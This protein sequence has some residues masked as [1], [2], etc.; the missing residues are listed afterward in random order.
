MG[1]MK[2]LHTSDWHLGRALYGRKRYDEFSDFLDWIL[3][4][5]TRTNID[6]LVIAGDIFDTGTPSNRAQ[7]LYYNFLCNIAKSPCRHVIIIGGNHDSPSFLSAPGQL[8]RGLDIHVVGAMTECPE[9]EVILLTDPQGKAEALICAVPYLRD[10]DIRT[11]TPGESLDDKNHKLIQGLQDHYARIC[12]MAVARQTALIAEGQAKIPIIATGHLFTAGGQTIDGDGVRDL[13][14]GSLAHMGSDLFP[15]SIDYLALGH[16]HVPQIVGKKNHF[17]YCGSPIA[18]GF[19]EAK[20]QKKIILVEFDGT[21]PKIQEQDVPIFQKLKL[22]RGDWDHIKAEITDLC[23]QQESVWLEIDYIGNALI[24]NLPD[25]IQDLI[26]DSA[27]EV[28]RIKN[29]SRNAQF[30]ANSEI[31]ETLDDLTPMEVFERCLVAYDVDSA[32]QAPLIEAYQDILRH[33][34]EQDSRAE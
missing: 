4:Y 23:A 18:M 31:R 27:L 5:I 6:I 7:Q 10:K 25:Q 8:L 15:E 30:S 16:L 24:S 3:E 14:V 19:G 20:Q 13:Y 26:G 28:L 9:D 12:Q 21:V 11:V 34:A 33:M 1:Y 32:D 22:I 2:I 17:R 29:K